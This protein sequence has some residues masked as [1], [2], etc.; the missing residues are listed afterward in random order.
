M[1][2]GRKIKFVRK[3]G[4]DHT[5]PIVVDEKTDLLLKMSQI[6]NMMENAPDEKSFFEK[7][8]EFKVL[9]KKFKKAGRKKRRA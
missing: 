7:L 5:I 3:R 1:A 4:T 9:A 6:E 8:E 2:K